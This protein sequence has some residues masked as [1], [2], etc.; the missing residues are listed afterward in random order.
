MK[1]YYV[2]IITNY[3]KTV[4]YTGMTGDL[5]RRIKEHYN[6]EVEGF[7]SKFKCKYLLYY[8]KNDNVNITISREKQ[9]KK[10]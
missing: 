10:W 6:C 4:L 2:Y 3:N 1:C 9:I 8:E 5:K 7:S